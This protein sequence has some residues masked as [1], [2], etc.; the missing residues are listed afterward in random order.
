MNLASLLTLLSFVQ[1]VFSGPP[2]YKYD[3]RRNS[4]KNQA[5][6][7]IYFDPETGQFKRGNPPEDLL[8]KSKQ[9][10]E[11]IQQEYSQKQNLPFAKFEDDNEESSAHRYKF[12]QMH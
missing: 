9:L 8:E 1:L 5:S 12:S 11:E 2:S 10:R 3:Y 7:G 4:K 6:P